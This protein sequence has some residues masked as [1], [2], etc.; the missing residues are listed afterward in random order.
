MAYTT[1]NKPD[2][3][4]N[5]K[6]YTGNGSTL[7]LTGLG[8]QPDWVWIKRRN[9]V[10]SHMSF[11]SL[12]G[13]GKSLIPDTT[14]A[15][16]N[17]ANGLT[18]FGADGFTLGDFSAGNISGDDYVAWNWKAGTTGSG[19][20]GGS[21]TGK[22]YSYSVNT[23]AGFS[24]VK[25]IGNGTNGHTIPHHLG[26][27]PKMVIAK[28]TIGNT[29]NW[30]VYHNSLGNNKALYLDGSSQSTTDTFL[31]N[32]T[33]SSSV[34]TLGSNMSN[35]DGKTFIM[36][37]F[38]EKPGYSKFGTYTGNGNPNGTFVYTG[39]KPSFFMIKR[40]DADGDKWRMWDNKRSSFNLVDDSLAANEDSVEYDDVS[41]S[42]DFVS[43]GAKMRMS[44]GGAGNG[45]GQTYIF[46]AFAERPIVATNNIPCTGK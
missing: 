5:T 23:T 40:T 41:V 3:Y 8:F 39:F 20:T 9:T 2:E 12:R 35:Q 19:T 14:A 13:V 17:Q 44:G 37:S 28:V 7:A 24:I 43:N 45:Y 29:N 27:V 1:I 36:Y 34:V 6:I 30:G 33:P 26:A 38:A 4:V 15:E 11:D 18:A 46:M 16:G 31:N 10:Y 42:L 21:G 25:Y 32:T 22:A